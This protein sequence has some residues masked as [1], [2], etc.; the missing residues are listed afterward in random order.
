MRIASFNLE[1]LFDRA[2][3]LN[4]DL[5]QGINPVLEEFGELNALIDKAVYSAADKTRMLALL[6]AL[7][8]KESDTG[9]FVIL[10]QNRGRFIKRPRAG[11]IEIIAD[12][13]TDWVGWI[14]L[15]TEAVNERA[16]L[17]TADV[18]RDVNADIIATIEAENRTALKRFSETLLRGEGGAP[19]RHIMLI[20]GNDERGIDVGVMTREGFEIGDI[21]SHVDELKPDGEPLF[22]RDCAEFDITTAKGNK[23]WLLINHFK[24][25]I[26]DPRVSNAKR[27][28]QATRV[29]QIYAELRSAGEDHVAIVGDFNDTPASAPLTPL[30]STDLKDVATLANFQDGGFPGTFGGSTA[31]NKI[32]Y[33]LLSP[34][35]QAKVTGG[36]IFRKG[37]WPGVR[38]VKWAV[39][40]TLTKQVEAASDH[41]AIYVDLDF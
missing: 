3:A 37:M 4:G 13:R 38:P 40:P 2:K 20:D 1:N 29:A 34:A 24:S 33:I 9:S 17:H 31:G 8:L 10:R 36:G 14:E 11:G 5:D 32:D 27:K 12:G 30:L 28:A 19:Y 18:V 7:D 21:R 23:L 22:S 25:K 26:G 35:L 16:M 41:G 15:R 6:E 39:Y